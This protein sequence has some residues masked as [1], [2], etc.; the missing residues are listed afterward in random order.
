MVSIGRNDPCWCGSGKKYKKCHLA[1]D[2]QKEREQK[3]LLTPHADQEDVDRIARSGEERRLLDLLDKDFPLGDEDEELWD[4][5]EAARPEEKPEIYLEAI[6][7]GEVSEELAYDMLLDLKYEVD[8]ERFEELVDRLKVRSPRAYR[9]YAQEYSLW[10]IESVAAQGKHEKLRDLLT[11]FLED[12]T[13]V[14]RPLFDAIDVLMYF[15]ETELLLDLMK[16]T[17]RGVY[18]SEDFEGSALDFAETGVALAIAQHRDSNGEVDT[19]NP[20]FREAIFAFLPKIEP[21]AIAGLKTTEDPEGKA[22]SLRDIER[23]NQKGAGERIRQKLTE[24]D[25]RWALSVLRERPAL[26]MRAQL[27]R[28]EILG[29]QLATLYKGKDGVRLL[30]PK[31]KELD[32]YLGAMLGPIEPAPHR[33]AAMMELLP[34][35]LR[36]CGRH[37]L[38]SDKQV[39]EELSSLRDIARTAVTVLGRV[40]P[41]LAPAV[42]EAWQ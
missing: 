13:R 42:Q 7:S 19:T 27:A 35:Y 32:R 3:A 26:Y 28:L 34:D 5:F 40:T 39:E 2:E 36:F 23:D 11:P 37:G 25:A 33:A 24:L 22:I 31:P 14:T 18:D 29:F 41:E 30:L 12:P 38:L 9:T 15:G 10:M 20:E 4:R 21:R 16:A 8:E 17:A 6:E 1:E